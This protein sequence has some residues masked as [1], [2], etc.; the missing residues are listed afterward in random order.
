MKTKKIV[1]A[2]SAAMGLML[3]G[4]VL[5]AELGKVQLNSGLN[6]PLS[7][8]IDLI[9]PNAAE[10]K[11]LHARMGGSEAFH[12]AHLNLSPILKTVRF[13]LHSKA[14]G[15]M[16]MHLSSD[17]PITTPVLDM[18]IELDWD[19]G[20]TLQEYRLSLNPAGLNQRIQ[21][22]S[23]PVVTGTIAGKALLPAQ[24]TPGTNTIP[25][26]QI[27]LIQES[28]LE[29]NAFTAHTICI[30]KGMTLSAIAVQYLP[31]GIHLDQMLLALYQ[32]NAQAFDGN[33]SRMQAGRTLRMPDRNELAAIN[34]HVAEHEVQIQAEAWDR[35]RQ[36]LAVEAKHSTVRRASSNEVR[37]HVE[38]MMPAKIVS[39]GQSLD[40]LKLSHEVLPVSAHRGKTLIQPQATAIE[41]KRMTRD[42]MAARKK[43]LKEEKIRKALLEENS[44]N[45]QKLLALKKQAMNEN[46]PASLVATVKS[47]PDAVSVSRSQSMTKWYKKI[48]LSDVFAGGAVVLLLVWLKSMIH[49]RKQIGQ[50]QKIYPEQ[51]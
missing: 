31:H 4:A 24:Q 18:L 10:L 38:A 6:Q 33:M 41:K 19:T 42:D 25:Q 32:K 49:H 40:E 23:N 27:P 26:S 36:K 16:V 45:I 21:R 5:G 43:A 29:T 1:I 48:N 13:Q 7:A 35:Y 28:A 9:V 30:Q 17:Q 3:N 37:G 47:S 2:V 34:E 14:D 11:H 51:I 39:P 20:M 8:D 44:R 46:K 22:A 12:R 50:K 15:S